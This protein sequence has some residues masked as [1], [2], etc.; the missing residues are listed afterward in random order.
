V[1]RV[2]AGRII[3][4]SD[5]P[6]ILYPKHSRRPGFKRFLDEIAGAGLSAGERAAILGSNIRRLLPPGPAGGP[7]ASTTR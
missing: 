1:D 7:V 3:Y 4:G 5:Y 6:L 2:G